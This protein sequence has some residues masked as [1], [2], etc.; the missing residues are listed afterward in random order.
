[1]FVGPSAKSLYEALRADI[2]LVDEFENISLLKVNLKP[3][4]QL[5]ILVTKRVLQMVSLLILYVTNHRVE[6]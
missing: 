2:L 4:K 6:L 3:L 5:Q 1:M